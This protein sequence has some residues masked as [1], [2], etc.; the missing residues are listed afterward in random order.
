MKI[1]AVFFEVGGH[2]LNGAREGNVAVVDNRKGKGKA[3][4]KNGREEQN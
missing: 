3:V 2:E 4:M 1:D